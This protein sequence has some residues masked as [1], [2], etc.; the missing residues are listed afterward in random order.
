MNGTA[1]ATQSPPA[2]TAYKEWGYVS[3][4]L[5]VL[6]TQLLPRSFFEGMI[7]SRNF[8]D[9]RSALAKT[10]YRTVFVTDEQV[11]D[12]SEALDSAEK[13]LQ[14][15]ILDVSPPHV[16]ASFFE[17]PRRYLVFRSLFLRAAARG[18]SVSDLEAT[19]ESLTADLSELAALESHIAA[20]RSREAPQSADAVARSL[21][22]D[23]AVC[24]LQ[25]ALADSAPE[26]KVR[27]LLHD[28]AVLKSWS[29]VLRSRWNGTPADVIRRWFMVKE[30][31]G[32][33][34]RVTAALAES[35]PAGGLA[36]CLSDGAL[37]VLRA[38]EADTI[39]RNVD[40][41]AGETIRDQA[42]ELR[43]VTYGPERVLAYFAAIA[44]EQE[45]LRLV[46][47]SIVNGVEPRIVLE[48]LRR[49][50]A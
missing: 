41:A 50:Y 48:R 37:R 43:M 40:A 19:F 9:A 36:G 7:R 38:L 23:S 30:A 14:K 4:R 22:L 31:Y 46:L 35:N 16:L 12:Y 11:R 26:E 47:S 8:S 17:M 49:E 10:T 39:R 42:L 3:G 15:D 29:A 20:M 21:Y 27:R 25:L 33:M 45:N 28:I 34:V 24:A 13:T 32:E 1:T 18:A 5:S 2:V 6:E 44:V